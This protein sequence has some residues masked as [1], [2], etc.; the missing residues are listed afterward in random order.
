MPEVP[1]VAEQPHDAPRI[2]VDEWVASAEERTERHEGLRGLAR[3]AVERTPP[4]F[5]LAVFVA[6]A[7]TLPLFLSSGNLFRYGFF[8]LVY[9]LLGLGLNVTLGFTGILDLGYVA[10]YGFG[11]YTYAVLSSDIHGIHWPAEVTIPVVVGATAVLGL[12]LGLPSRR[13]FGDYLAIVTLFFGQAFVVFVNNANPRGLTGGANGIGNI[14]NLDVFGYV[15]TTTRQYYYFALGAFVVVIAV[16]WSIVRSRIGRAW[17]ALREDALAAEL[18]S[19]PVFRLRLL[20]FMFGAGIAGLTGAI[21]APALTGVAPG[22]FDVSIL[23]TIYAVVILG[24]AGS[25]PGVVLGAI[26]INVSYELLT[27]ETPDRARWLFYGTLIVVLLARVRPWQRL[28]ALL[29][30]TA[31]FG[32]AIHAVTAAVSSTGTNGEVNTGGFLT[33][34]IR[35]WVVIPQNPGRLVDYAYIALVVMVIVLTR[36]K[37][38]WRTLSLIPTLYLGAFVWENLLVQQPAVTRN[39]LFGAL[40]IVL[41]NVRPQGLLGTAR[42]E[43]V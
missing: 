8:T 40:L 34:P 42:V 6:L 38:W 13:L 39:V 37:G 15:L 24:G 29:A 32:F 31:A 18:M 33:D 7:A 43:I 30:G 28:A 2:G 14:D 25:L 5:R 12:L 10:F 19:I 16:L 4:P 41:M 27:P 21:V 1:P 35:S 17:M 23:I 26:V 9:V 22:Q 20:A 3:D 36:V 11:A